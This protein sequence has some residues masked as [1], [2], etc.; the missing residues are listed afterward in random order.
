MS[1]TTKISELIA[2]KDK[3]LEEIRCLDEDIR[4]LEYEIDELTKLNKQAQ[5]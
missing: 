3:I 4:K 5:S 1:N 2:Q